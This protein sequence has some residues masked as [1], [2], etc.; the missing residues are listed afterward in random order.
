MIRKDVIIAILATF[1]LTTTLLIV[2]PTRSSPTAGEYDSWVDVNDDGKINMYD[3]GYAAARF[4]TTGDPTKYVKVVNWPV[5][6]QQT[7]FF[8]A[9]GGGSSELYNVSGFGHMHLT[10][11]V[12]SLSGSEMITFR[13]IGFIYNSSNVYHSFP[14]QSLK[15]NY[16]NYYGSFSFPLPTDVVR[17]DYLPAFETT[18]SATLAFYLTYA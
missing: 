16:T 17:F 10:W 3:L 18:A 7:V 15:V 12:D 8:Q 14:V 5:A 6:K 2:L 13:I 11:I 9:T 1:C 4:G